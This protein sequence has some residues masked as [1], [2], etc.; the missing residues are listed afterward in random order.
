MAKNS[1]S[2]N[3]KHNDSNGQFVNEILTS[4]LSYLAY[5]EHI[6]K[7]V[8]FFKITISITNY[9]FGNLRFRKLTPKKPHKTSSF[10]IKLDLS[11]LFSVSY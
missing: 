9:G 8:I 6:F 10:P 7:R 5:Y 3:R 11:K 4:G 2:R 1:P